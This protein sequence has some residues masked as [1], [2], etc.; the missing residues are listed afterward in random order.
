MSKLEQIRTLDRRTMFKA[1]DVASP[2]ERHLTEPERKVMADALRASVQ[3][4][5]TSKARNKRWR[6]KNPDKYR[7]GQRELMRKRRAKT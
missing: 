1:V 5:V 2:N 7:A 4:V 3:T 6:E